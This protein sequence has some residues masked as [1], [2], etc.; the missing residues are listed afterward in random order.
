MS[1]GRQM[2]TTPGGSNRMFTGRPG[3]VGGD[4]LRTSRS[5]GP[6]FAGWASST[7]VRP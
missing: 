7:K 4:V 6:I 2:G 3:D 5:R 1:P